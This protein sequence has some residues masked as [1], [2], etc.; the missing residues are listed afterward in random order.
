M[1]L[2]GCSH[3]TGSLKIRSR[4]YRALLTKAIASRNT[5]TPAPGLT[6]FPAR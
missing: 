2:E 6:P 4:R 1:R 5:L 3:R